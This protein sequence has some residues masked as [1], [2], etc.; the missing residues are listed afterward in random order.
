MA[1]STVRSL[2]P[3]AK[4]VGVGAGAG[5]LASDSSTTKR[6][7][8]TQNFLRCRLRTSGAAHSAMGQ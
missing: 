2:I 5:D 8:E 6:L 1:A 7:H 4:L 3:S